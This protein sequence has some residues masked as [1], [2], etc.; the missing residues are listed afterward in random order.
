MFSL[1]IQLLSFSKSLARNRT[2]SLFLNDEPFMV[3]PT[4]IDM[5]PNE[6]KYRFM[7]SLNKCTGSCVCL[8]V[9]HNDVTWLGVKVDQGLPSVRHHIPRSSGKPL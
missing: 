4:L 5:N 7:I 1:F 9:N 2:K 3:R 8:R 6:L